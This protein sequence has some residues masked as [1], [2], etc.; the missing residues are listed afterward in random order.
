MYDKMSPGSKTPSILVHDSEVNE[1]PV[2]DLLR[3]PAYVSEA[4]PAVIAD[5]ISL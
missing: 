4:S 3:W 2:H 5:H 1:E